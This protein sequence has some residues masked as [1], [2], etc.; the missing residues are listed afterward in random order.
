MSNQNTLLGI[1]LGDIFFWHGGRGKIPPS[2]QLIG[3]ELYHIEELREGPAGSHRTGEEPLPPHSPP[4][5]PPGPLGK[6]PFILPS[7]FRKDSEPP[8]VS[9]GFP[10]FPTRSCPPTT[11]IGSVLT[12]LCPLQSNLGAP[13]ATSPPSPHSHPQAGRGF[14][15]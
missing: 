2:H 4:H 8:V 5:S 10:H 6:F 1:C 9:T 15:E 13:A 14:G 7:F 11:G 3:Y 12:Q